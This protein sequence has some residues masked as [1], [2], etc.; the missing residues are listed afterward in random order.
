MF[1]LRD[2]MRHDKTICAVKYEDILANKVE[3][4]RETFEKLGLD[5]NNMDAA[6]TAFDKHSL[7]ITVVSR[8]RVGQSSTYVI[9]DKTDRI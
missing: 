9:S 1:V 5:L 3:T 6:L 8:S 7:R 4:F 2:A